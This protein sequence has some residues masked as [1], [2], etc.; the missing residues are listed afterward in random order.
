LKAEGTSSLIKAVEK[1]D[2][3]SKNKFSTYAGYWIKQYMQ[4]FINKNQFINQGSGTKE[5]SVIY[6]DSNYQN[7]DKESKSYSLMETLHDDENAELT[8]E[9]VR[10]QDTTIQIN[11]LINTLGNREEILLVRLLSKVKPSNLLDVYYLA[12]EEEKKELKKKMKLSDKSNPELLQ[13]HSWEKKEI[14]NLPSV[15]NYL[16]LFTKNY[17]FSEISK[18]LGKSENTA[19]RLKQEAFKKLQKLAKERNLHFLIR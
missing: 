4:S 6:Y 17:K 2:L 5:K 1:F 13:K 8:A 14:H 7:D 16:S 10:H 9:Q 3:S 12:T 11:N 15:K 19:R 18:I